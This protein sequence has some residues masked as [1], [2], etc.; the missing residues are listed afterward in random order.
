MACQQ[1]VEAQGRGMDALLRSTLGA[2]VSRSIVNESVSSNEAK[3]TGIKA[4]IH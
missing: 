3:E 4:D 2:E 1:S